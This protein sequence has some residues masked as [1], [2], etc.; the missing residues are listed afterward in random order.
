M[1]IEIKRSI[2]VFITEKVIIFKVTTIAKFGYGGSEI[3][4]F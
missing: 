1:I 2:E 3:G 4:W